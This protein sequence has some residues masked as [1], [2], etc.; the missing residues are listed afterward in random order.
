MTVAESEEERS[1]LRATN[2]LRL[3]KMDDNVFPPRNTL[4][5]S[6]PSNS[7]TAAGE[8]TAAVIHDTNTR[9]V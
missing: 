5:R 4:S 1:F 2:M 3:E 7:G 8:V 9:R 6:P